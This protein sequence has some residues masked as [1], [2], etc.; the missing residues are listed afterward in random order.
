[1]PQLNL[2]VLCLVCSFL[3]D[4]PGV[5]AF[6]RT[7]YTLRAAAVQ[8]RL[9][10][11]PVQ[12][13]DSRSI[14]D[15]Y[16]FVFVDKVARGPHIHTITIPQEAA[17]LLQGFP[18]ELLHRLLAILSAATR[19]HTLSLYLPSQSSSLL[20]HP[21]IVPAVARLTEIRDLSLVASFERADAL[22]RCI[23][24]PIQAFRYE[25]LYKGAAWLH[26]RNF[27]SASARL[28]AIRS[29]RAILQEVDGTLALEDVADH[30]S[31]TLC[32][33]E[34]PYGHLPIRGFSQRQPVPFKFLAVR[35]FTLRDVTELVRLDM[36]LHMLPNLDDTLVVEASPL[37]YRH[38]LDRDCVETTRENNL[39]AQER[40]GWK[41]LDR[42][43]SSPLMVF[44][45]GLTCPVRHL[46]LDL[47]A[48]ER[49]LLAGLDAI[50]RDARC[51]V[52][53]DQTPTHLTLRGLR[54][55]AGLSYLDD[56]FSTDGALARTTHLVV[57]AEYNSVEDGKLLWPDDVLVSISLS[58]N[59]VFWCDS[60]SYAQETLLARIEY[61][62]LTHVRI[63]VNGLISDAD[64][65]SASVH[66]GIRDLS[67]ERLAPQFQYAVQSLSHIFLT[68]RGV[69]VHGDKK[70]QEVWDVS[71]AWR[72][73]PAA[74]AVSVFGQYLQE[75]S[76][77]DAE[78]VLRKEDMQM[79]GEPSWKVCLLIKAQ[80]R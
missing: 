70:L 72:V 33:L 17:P 29:H 52:L 28:S 19:V 75:L 24:S 55:P 22:L 26:N 53:R 34:L 59:G 56:L 1:M 8:R 13:T 37:F 61:L 16:E 62:G 66:H 18:E 42:V 10:M 69:V 23:R 78:A 77:H 73:P 5:L 39:L 7:C 54:L 20:A 49:S 44:T 15:L 36:L 47:S 30:L 51:A 14:N 76:A 64:P 50:A 21:L 65:F 2:D 48:D 46:T 12:I 74:E 79:M 68:S 6:S 25:G 40:H 45:L 41:K 35:S 60:T 57:L 38:V 80:R 58:S 32:E 3:T 67:L 11:R 4:I 27:L 9:N 31:R 43:V 71:K 63:V